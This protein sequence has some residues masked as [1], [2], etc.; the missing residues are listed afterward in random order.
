MSSRGWSAS[1]WQR[2]L[3]NRLLS[4]TMPVLAEPSPA[5]V[6]PRPRQMATR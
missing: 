2:H 1:T 3:V 4:K 5:G 6:Q